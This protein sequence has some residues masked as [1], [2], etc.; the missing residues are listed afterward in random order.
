[1]IAQFALRLIVGMSAM[2]AVMP[3]R[4]VASGFF[5]IQMLV[6]LGLGVFAALTIGQTETSGFTRNAIQ[7]LCMAAAGCAFLGSVLWTLERR[8]GATV[9]AMMLLGLSVTA[10]L[11][12][13]LS[14]EAP[15]GIIALSVLSELSTAS[16]MGGLVAAMLLGHWYLTAPGMKLR[17]LSRCN[18]VLGGFTSARFALSLTG[19][20]VGGASLDSQTH[21]L[22][23]TLRWGAGIVGPAILI[24]MVHRILKYRNTQSATGMLF[25]GVILSFIGELSATLLSAE[26]DVPF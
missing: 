10:L 7:G 23:L 12:V 4:D 22:W 8:T 2:W 16:L 3:R 11:F 19:L 21:W 26:L 1:M 18:G 14:A 5:R 9:V 17:P 15:P 13:P 24:V 6:T 20:F 25:V